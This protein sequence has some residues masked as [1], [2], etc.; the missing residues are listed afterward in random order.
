MEAWLGGPRLLAWEKDFSKKRKEYKL[1]HWKFEIQTI[2]F[3]F[4]QKGINIL[5]SSLRG[6][7][8]SSP[9]NKSILWALM[10]VGLFLPHPFRTL[11]LFCLVL[12]RSIYKY[13]LGFW[14][15]F[16][17]S[18][19]VLWHSFL[20]YKQIR[21]HKIPNYR[22]II[23]LHLSHRPTYKHEWNKFWFSFHFSI[24]NRS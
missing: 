21:I 10:V 5:T 11:R 7:L 8:F 9:T 23:F 6:I 1:A 17:S 18:R 15:V 12:G 2:S 20:M 13:W 24:T 19:V 14:K 4:F 3:F 22:R 16:F